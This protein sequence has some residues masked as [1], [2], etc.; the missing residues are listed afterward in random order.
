MENWTDMQLNSSKNIPIML[1]NIHRDVSKVSM[2]GFN[3]ENK[4]QIEFV[5]TKDGIQ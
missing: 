2:D 1:R 4:L 3:S 5:P